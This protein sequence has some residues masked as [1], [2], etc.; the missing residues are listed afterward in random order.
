VGDLKDYI[1]E[2]HGN[3]TNLPH[4]A[5]EGHGIHIG[6]IDSAYQLPDNL[7][8]DMHVV[9]SE[10]NS[11]IQDPQP[12]AGNHCRNVFNRM[13]CYAPGAKY[14]LYQAVNTDGKLPMGA[15]SDAISKAIDDDVDIVNI[16]AGDPWPGPVPANPNVSETKRLIENGIPAVIAAGNYDPDEQDERP[17]VHCPSALTEAISVGAMVT[18]CPYDPD[19]E[20]DTDRTGPYYW[21]PDDPD[22][23]SEGGV[24]E[25]AYCG[26]SGC[27]DG[28]SCITNQQETDWDY[29]PLPTGGKPDVLAPMHIVQ[30]DHAGEYFLAGGTSFA[31]PLV[32]G[33]LARI[34]SELKNDGRD[35]P[36]PHEVR[37]AV[38]AGCAEIPQ[39]Q[40]GKYHAMGVR[41]ALDV[42]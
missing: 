34:L 24:I 35:L 42:T 37:D 33:S 6:I 38:R 9:Q 36:P 22:V 15:Y 28:E 17:P 23:D 2:A 16:S 14:T 32:T 31:A 41:N 25:E 7:T 40:T 27:R 30:Q 21:L 12:E 1:I 5:A 26:E 3:R 18:E 13:Q 29:N 20:V 19:P 39:V 10:S 11:F 8:A 4:A